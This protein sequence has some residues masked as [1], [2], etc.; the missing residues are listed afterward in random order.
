MTKSCCGEN[1]LVLP[2]CKNKRNIPQKVTPIAIKMTQA[3]KRSKTII[4]SEPA[5]SCRFNQI[6]YMKLFLLQNRRR[7]RLPISLM[8]KDAVKFGMY[9]EDFTYIDKRTKRKKVLTIPMLN[10]HEA[11]QVI[12]D[13]TVTSC[14][15]RF[16]CIT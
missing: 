11:L 3:S 8:V 5:S 9:K 6:H 4:S 13:V 10:A 15:L 1:R 16:V 14:V 2:K 12:Y 7:C